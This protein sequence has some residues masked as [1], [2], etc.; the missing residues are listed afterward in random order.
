MSDFGDLVLGAS[1]D[2]QTQSEVETSTINNFWVQFSRTLWLL[3]LKGKGDLPGPLSA[4]PTSTP[5][6][7]AACRPTES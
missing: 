2:L 1:C 5:Q 3:S 7:S 6:A 4:F